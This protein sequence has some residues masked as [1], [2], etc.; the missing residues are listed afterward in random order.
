MSVLLKS[1][2]GAE[3]QSGQYSAIQ[4]PAYCC[5]FSFRDDSLV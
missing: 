4:V 5:M 2:E 3:M 1:N